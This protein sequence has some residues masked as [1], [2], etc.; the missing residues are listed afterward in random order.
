MKDAKESGVITDSNGTEWTFFKSGMAKRQDFRHIRGGIEVSFDIEMGKRGLK[1]S[2]F[3]KMI[4]NRRSYFLDHYYLGQ[5]IDIKIFVN[6]LQT[7]GLLLNSSFPR[8]T[9]CI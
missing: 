1:V 7:F 9:T 2:F 5:P 3:F 4:K 6:R 8:L